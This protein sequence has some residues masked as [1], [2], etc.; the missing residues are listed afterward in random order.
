M[1]EKSL[2]SGVTSSE[3][4][5][6]NKQIQTGEWAQPPTIQV[7]VPD[8]V[9]A[10]LAQA[11][12]LYEELTPQQAKAYKQIAAFWSSATTFATD[13]DMSAETAQALA[14]AQASNVFDT[15]RVYVPTAK[16]EHIMDAAIIGCIDT[17]GQQAKFFRINP[18]RKNSWDTD[19]VV[20]WW[21]AHWWDNRYHIFAFVMSMVVIVG[22]VVPSIL[23]VVLHDPFLLGWMFLSLFIALICAAVLS[24]RLHME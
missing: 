18:P 8:G 22:V 5:P 3:V 23:A 17:A 16:L 7:V 14:M 2:A 15:I 6:T 21:K 1:T 20:N 12:E 24:V 19:S 10:K 4:E 13:G 9:F 11:R